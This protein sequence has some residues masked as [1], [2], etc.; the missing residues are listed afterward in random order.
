MVFQNN[1]CFTLC[2]VS[3]V[4]QSVGFVVSGYGLDDRAIEVRFPAEAK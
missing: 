4:A 2:Y 1:V 3:R